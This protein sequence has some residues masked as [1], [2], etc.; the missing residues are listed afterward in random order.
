MKRH[1]LFDS[2][3]FNLPKDSKHINKKPTVKYAMT[4]KQY[5]FDIKHQ[6][7][8]DVK[9]GKGSKRVTFLRLNSFLC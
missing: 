3:G 9:T 8:I 5:E 7:W 4:Y 1:R 6:D 2:I